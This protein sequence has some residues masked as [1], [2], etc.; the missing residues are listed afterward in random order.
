[1]LK[2]RTVSLLLV[3]CISVSLLTIGNALDA[4][5]STYLSSYSATVF[6]E[7]NGDMS[8][9]VVVRGLKLM[10]K[11]GVNSM[12]IEEKY[13]ENGSWH[14]YDTL[15]GVDD[16]DTFYFYGKRTFLNSIPFKGTPGYYYRVYATV[17]AG[18]SEGCD[19]GITPSNSALCK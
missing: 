4:R 1:M 18:D 15:Y 2:K 9:D 17:Y 3:I 16:P 6:A 14:Y 10:D 8:V 13:S 11:I 19:T 12:R 7:S 5:A